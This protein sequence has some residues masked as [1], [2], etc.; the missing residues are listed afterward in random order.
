MARFQVFVSSLAKWSFLR[1]S[2]EIKSKR[3]E[4]VIGAPANQGCWSSTSHLSSTNCPK[5]V[6]GIPDNLKGRLPFPT[7]L[8]LIKPYSQTNYSDFNHTVLQVI[9]PLVHL[10]NLCSH[11]FSLGIAP[12]YFF[13]ATQ[14]LNKH[15]LNLWEM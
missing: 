13:S 15:T 9:N 8:F 6:C 3:D 4:N 10:I 5:I 12:C 2:M 14:A 7:P 1:S 11:G